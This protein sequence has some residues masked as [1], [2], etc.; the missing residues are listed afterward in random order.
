MD[1]EA[2]QTLLTDLRGPHHSYV[3]DKDYHGDANVSLL[4]KVACSPIFNSLITP[5]RS[6]Q[7]LSR[8]PDIFQNV[9]IACQEKNYGMVTIMH[10]L[11]AVDYQDLAPR[12][13]ID[14]RSSGTTTLFELWGEFAGMVRRQ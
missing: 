9:L 4:V 7:A 12:D 3:T 2:F 8:K 1:K 14:R 10:D 11:S 13:L 6:F 5:E